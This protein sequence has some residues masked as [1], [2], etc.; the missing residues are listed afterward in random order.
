MYLEQASA[1]TRTVRCV[2]PANFIMS[3]E[4]T[5]ENNISLEVI[6]FGRDMKRFDNLWS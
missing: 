6:S 4:D 2:I 5:E 3:R 1:D